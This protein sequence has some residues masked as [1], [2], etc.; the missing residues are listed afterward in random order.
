MADTVQR[1]QDLVE[2][3]DSKEVKLLAKIMQDYVQKESKTDMGFKADIKNIKQ[4]D[5]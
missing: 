1:L 3:V 4:G 2:V 5:K